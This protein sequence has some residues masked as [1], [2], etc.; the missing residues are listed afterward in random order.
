MTRLGLL[1]YRA[2]HRDLDYGLEV[3]NY[4]EIREN[5][6]TFELRL[7]GENVKIEG[8]GMLRE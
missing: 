1:G 3:G 2:S 8:R 7:T 4:L 5:G 6:S